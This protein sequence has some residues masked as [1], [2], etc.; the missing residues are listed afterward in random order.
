MVETAAIP[1]AK[2]SAPSAPSSAAS[3]SS[4]TATVGLP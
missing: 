4:V 1:E 3:F 2:A